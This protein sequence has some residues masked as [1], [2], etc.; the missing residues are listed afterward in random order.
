MRPSRILPLTLLAVA[1]VVPPAHAAQET[2]RGQTA[3]IVGEPGG[4]VTGTD[5]DD[6]IVTNG[7]TETDAG[8]GAD[9]ICVTG[10][11]AYL[12]DAGDGD[13]VVDTTAF[14]DLHDQVRVVL[15]TGADTFVGGSGR[16]T[17]TTGTDLVDADTDRVTTGRGH[18]YVFTGQRLLADQDDVDLGRGNDHLFLAS[19][20]NGGSL[21]GGPAKNDVSLDLSAGTWVVDDEADELRRAG[22]V[23]SRWAAL[24]VASVDGKRGVDVRYV[25]SGGDDHLFLAVNLRSA[26]LGTGDDLLFFDLGGVVTRRIAGGPG[27]DSLNA[28]ARTS[29]DLDLRQHRLARSTDGDG[30]R[31]AGLEY[32]RVGADRVR[33]IGGPR[34]DE[35]GYDGCTVHVRGNGGGDRLH[36][37]NAGRG[38]EDRTR[39]RVLGG[40]G[41]DRL[42]GGPYRDHLDGGL[43]TDLARGQGDVDWCRA[44]TVSGCEEP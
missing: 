28:F 22:T 41:D 23:V 21:D 6:V 9:T 40:R 8:A 20:H 16:D 19:D 29:V 5:G 24:G 13:D 42:R 43:G 32:Y 37:V 25:G 14:D 2:C 4:T 36:W 3:T 1:L 34:A 30:Y 33:M 15:G 17:V 7:A 11:Y 39:F 35:L 10:G 27:H 18:D 31:L 38:C 12:V 44:E 26:D